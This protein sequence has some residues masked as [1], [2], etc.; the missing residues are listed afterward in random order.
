MENFLVTTTSHTFTGDYHMMLFGSIVGSGCPCNWPAGM[1]GLL[2]AGLRKYCPRS[3]RVFSI[4]VG[5][6]R[7]PLSLSTSF[8]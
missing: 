2:G 1:T 5:T 3:G 8:L 7:Y 6:L 4:G